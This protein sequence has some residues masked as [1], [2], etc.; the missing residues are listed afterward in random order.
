MVPSFLVHLL[1]ASFTWHTGN[2]RAL[3]LNVLLSIIYEPMRIWVSV[4]VKALFWYSSDENP[5]FPS[6]FD[7]FSFAA[8]H[9]IF[10]RS[11]ECIKMEEYFWL[12]RYNSHKQ[13]RKCLSYLLPKCILKAKIWVDFKTVRRLWCSKYCTV[14][15]GPSSIPWRN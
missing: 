1:L 13:G 4:Q 7:S 15:G 12:T 8:W 9:K 14:A 2:D 10:T 5:I 3:D 6:I 11:L